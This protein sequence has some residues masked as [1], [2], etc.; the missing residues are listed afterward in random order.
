MGH[1]GEVVVA[2]CGIARGGYH[3]DMASEMGGDARQEGGVVEIAGEHGVAEVA[4]HD[5]IVALGVESGAH[6]KVADAAGV[7]G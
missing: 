4:L 5:E 7:G 3:G 1:E 6:L 2:L